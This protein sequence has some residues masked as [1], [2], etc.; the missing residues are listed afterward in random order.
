MVDE[1]RLKHHN[2]DDV[3]RYLRHLQHKGF[4]G[5]VNLGFQSGEITQVEPKSVIKPGDPLT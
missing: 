3:L 4:Y 5:T 1:K 2:F